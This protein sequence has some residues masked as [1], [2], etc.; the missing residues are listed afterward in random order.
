MKNY[1]AGNKLIPRVD[2]KRHLFILLV[3]L[4]IGQLGTYAGL[5][6]SSVGSVVERILLEGKRDN[7]SVAV[8][9]L[10]AEYYDLQKAIGTD[11][12]D[13]TDYIL[14]TGID[15]VSPDGRSVIM[16]SRNN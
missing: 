14:A 10:E 8:A 1:N 3:I 2:K 16:L 4:M 12:A 6:N 15:Y 7:L 13:R 9:E 5:I 11:N